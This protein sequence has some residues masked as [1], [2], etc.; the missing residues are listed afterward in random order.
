MTNSMIPNAISMG[1]FNRGNHTIFSQGISN[2]LL[3]TNKNIPPR[4]ITNL[5]TR[6][7]TIVGKAS[8]QRH[9]EQH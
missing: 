7:P 2:D 3:P 8:F 6:N 4:S 9:L 1:D 5:D